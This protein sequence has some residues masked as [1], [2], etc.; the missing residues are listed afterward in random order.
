V[1]PASLNE[2]RLET[3]A[4][5][6]C[7]HGTA[8]DP[9]ARESL[10]GCVSVS[11]S[12][13]IGVPLEAL[14][15]G[16]VNTPKRKIFMSNVI[17]Q[18]QTAVEGETTPSPTVTHY[19]QIAAQ[20]SA[21]ITT[22]LQ[23]I[24][25]LE[26][27]HPTTRDFVRANAS[28]S[29]DFIVSVIAAVE[30]TSELQG[31]KFNVVEARDMLQ[32]IEAFRPVLDLIDVLARKL[33][34]TMD[35]RKANVAEDALHVY[36]LGKRYARSPNSTTLPHVEIMRREL[37]RARPRPRDKQPVPAPQGNKTQGNKTEGNKPEGNKEVTKT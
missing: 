24:A 15:K 3:N 13:V 14:T 21:A 36:A 10:P 33:K 28:V 7:R 2:R 18:S 8:A 6:F 27:P 17:R 1:S 35:A 25:P 16:G 19:Q 37:G 9:N 31:T 22:A 32:F 26:A 11:A 20:V 23:Q 12:T 30:S 29:I 34:F 4:T 5:V